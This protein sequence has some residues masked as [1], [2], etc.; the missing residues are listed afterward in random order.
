MVV[1]DT[2]SFYETDCVGVDVLQLLPGLND[3]ALLVLDKDYVFEDFDV[4][5][6]IVLVNFAFI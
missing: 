5:V 4:L 2:Q 1:E 3:H 6:F